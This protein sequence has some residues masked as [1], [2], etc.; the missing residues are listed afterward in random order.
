MRPIRANDLIELDKNLEVVVLQC[1]PIPEQVVYQ[2]GK[3]DYSETPIHHQEI[4]NPT[5][6]GEW[7]VERLLSNDKGHYGCY[8]SDTQVLTEEGWVYWTEVTTDTVL[9]AY[10][11]STGIVNFEKPSAVQRWDYND[12]MYHLEG[13][14]LD[15]L[16]S[17]DHR[18]IV[19]NRKNDGSWSG[20][21]GMTANK[22]YGKPVRYIT[23]GNLS[24]SNRT[25]ISTPIDNPSFWAL[26]GFWIGDGDIHTSKNTL[27]FH[28]KKDRK[29]KY[30]ET[31]C[32]ELD[33][34]FY[35]TENDRYVVSYP[36]I[37]EWMKSNCSTI[38]RQKRFPNGYLR[39]EKDCVHNLL[40]GLKNSD[41][42][43]RRNTWG[44]STTSKLLS[45]QIQALASVNDLRFTC[46]VEER[47]NP[48]HSDLYLLRMTDRI[49][50]R[51]E[52]NQATRSKTYKEEWVDY[53]GEIHCATVSTGALIVR[54]NGKV[55][56]CGNCLEHPSITFSV[57]GYVHSVMVQARTHRV[58]LSFD[59][60][61][62]ESNIT[63]KKEK[64]IKTKTISELYEMYNR[65]EKLPLVR[66]LNEVRGYFDYA[67]IGKVFKNSEKELYLV[68]LEDGKQLK[69]SLDHRI[70]TENGWQRLKDL[71][72]G[73]KVACNGV[74]LSSIQDAR[75]KYTNPIW[76]SSELKTNSPKQIA[77]N[78]GVSYEVIKKYAYKFGLTW[79]IKKDHNR[80]KKL[81]TS[82]FT[83]EQNQL[84]KVNAIKNITKAHKKIEETGHPGRKYPNDTEN[85]VYNWQKYNRKKI[86]EHYG[87]IC[88]N[89]ESTTK[90]HCHHKTPIKDDIS[91]A[92]DI[93]NYEIL[94]SGCHIKE[95]KSLRTHFV[96]IASIEF[97]RTDITYDIEVNGKYHNFVCDGV[98]V[99]NCQSQRYTGKRVIKV[100]SGELTPEDV[101]Y[102]RPP[103]FYV[104]RYGKKYD[105]TEDDYN[106][107]LSWIL[108]GC[109]RYAV[110][111]EKGMCE[112]HIRDYLAQAIRQNFVVSF[113]LRSVLH[114]MDLR[115][116]MDAQLEI[117]ALCEQLIVPIQ[118][119]APNVWKYYEEK[120][121]RK[122]KLSP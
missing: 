84:R 26:I 65:G 5:K 73:D 106:D 1:Y 42:T 40:D 117:Q 57:S 54:R 51:V 82:H 58:G 118:N 92:Y 35:A 38:E 97:L 98:V 85:R 55:A 59:C 120:R 110:K 79:E 23:T 30:L 72:V 10:N 60:L 105:W 99:H 22:V 24:N 64:K 43:I 116:K 78:L 12:K 101:F 80:G 27:R 56:I 96:S 18:M 39:L 8:S 87:E 21:Y 7:I 48:N 112:E 37:G 94:C 86:L 4:P 15:F 13:Q 104:N 28:L 103:G 81:D 20:S 74:S 32:S 113:N 16:V 52:I 89:C 11:T 44:Y 2:A 95:H 100:A 3:N 41:G 63:V 34:D 33:I 70:F 90:L 77:I 6:C 121:L 83:D 49:Y 46:S 25:Y 19:Q 50:P 111:Y 76:L 122:A 88:S 108:E 61:A 29:I 66:N 9:A 109:K 68:T 119:W 91:R 107:E 47:D 93:E 75:E 62:G 45:E 67:E 31:L 71:S 36:E 115:A 14:S 114:F 102:V 53:I 69:C 17:P